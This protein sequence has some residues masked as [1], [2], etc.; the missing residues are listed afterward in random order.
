MS[1]KNSLKEIRMKEFMM[2]QN[3]FA[4]YLGIS[5]KNY[6][7][8][9]LNNSRPKLELALEIAKKLNKNVQEIWYLD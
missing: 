3:E 6:N 9:E 2:E 1:I 8:W 4:E 5:L 7:N